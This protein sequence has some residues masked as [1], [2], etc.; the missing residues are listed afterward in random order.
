VEIGLKARICRTLRWTTGFP[1]TNTEFQNKGN[2]K[3]HNLEVLLDY[4]AIQD[5]VRTVF[6]EDWSVATQWTPERR[7]DPR[8]TK[9]LV[10][11]E[12]MIAAAQNLLRVL[13]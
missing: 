8:G 5:H 2:L 13:L 9:S 7:Y 1:Q 3:T 10:E 11:A 6:L 12:E 4:T